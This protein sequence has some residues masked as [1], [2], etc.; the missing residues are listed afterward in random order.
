MVA[1]PETMQP[2]PRR[3]QTMG[4]VFMRG[5]VVMKGYLKNPRPPTRPSPAA[6]STPATS[7]SG[8]PTAMSS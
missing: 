3:R 7:A 6:G 1:D 8:T 5:N 2:V 4:E